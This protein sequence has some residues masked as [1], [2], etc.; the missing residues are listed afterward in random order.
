MTTGFYTVICCG[1]DPTIQTMYVHELLEKLEEKYWG[2]I[3]FLV[4]KAGERIDLNAREG[5]AI[6]EGLPVLPTAKEVA[7]RYELP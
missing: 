1:E 2:E 5:L 3:D 6:L 4:P 7:V